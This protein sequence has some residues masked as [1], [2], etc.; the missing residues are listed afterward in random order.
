VKA[1]KI[2]GRCFRRHRAREFR[3]FL[4]TVEHN[5]PAELA[6][7]V[8]MDNAGTHKTKLIRNWFAKRRHWHVHFTPTSA[9]W[10]SQVERFFALLTEQQLCRG[11]YPSTADLEAAIHAYIDTHNAEPKPFRWTKSADDILAAINRFCLR[12]LEAHSPG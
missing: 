8:I 5:V 1:G 9:S 6:V 10:I 3:K 4:D 2:I 11:V 7:H 12:T